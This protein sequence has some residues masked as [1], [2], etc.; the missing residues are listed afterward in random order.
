[1]KTQARAAGTERPPRTPAPAIEAHDLVKT[2][3]KG[4]RALNGLS[5]TV[6]PAVPAMLAALEHAGIAVH[7]VTA[8]RPSRGALSTAPD[9]SRVLTQGGAL[10]ALAIGVTAL[11][12]LT[13]RAYQK[14]V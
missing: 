9:W 5:F 14:S 13:F 1:M 7:G 12:V 4:I 11:S 3:P 6:E 2:Y 10:L 8:A